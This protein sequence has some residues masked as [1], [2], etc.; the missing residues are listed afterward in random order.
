MNY[1]EL[2]LIPLFML[3]DY[4]MTVLAEILRSKEYAQHYKIGSY[5]LN[6]SLQSDVKNR[7]W[8]SSKFYL[9]ATIIPAIIII[10][11]ENIGESIYV[12]LILG[13]VLISRGMLIGRHLSNSL[14]FRY[15][16][17]NPQQLSGEVTIGQEYLYISSMIQY[18][19][20]WV[21]LVIIALF[22]P[23]TFLIGGIIGA[24]QIIGLHALWLR[25]L[26]KAN[27]E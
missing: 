18:L 21:P 17:R 9:N 22:S 19:V 8:F 26:R 7:K 15:L 1:P 12:E 20:V 5:E 23:S 10:S 25:K 16:N 14:L 4:Y 3:V 2:F 6:P 11:L 27:S 24:T 13:F